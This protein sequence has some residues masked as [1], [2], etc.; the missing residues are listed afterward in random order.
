MYLRVFCGFILAAFWQFSFVSGA[1][2][3]SV[4]L[5]N[6]EQFTFVSDH[7]E[8]LRKLGFRVYYGDASR[9][10]LLKA[11]GAAETK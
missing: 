11:A 10:D 9:P 7:V 8:I 2:A 5:S 3:Q 1:S 6:T 4:T